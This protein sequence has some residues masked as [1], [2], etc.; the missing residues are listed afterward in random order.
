MASTDPQYW[1]TYFVGGFDH[2]RVSFP[3]KLREVFYRDKEQ[4]RLYCLGEESP[5]G[6]FLSFWESPDAVK[7]KAGIEVK[8]DSARKRIELPKQITPLEGRLVFIGGGQY[9][10]IHDHKKWMEVKDKLEFK[11]IRSELLTLRPRV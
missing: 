1:G 4:R 3:E 7:G 6:N 9:F 2:N 8:I 5:E 11:R 10:E